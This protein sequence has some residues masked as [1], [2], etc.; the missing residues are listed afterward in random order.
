MTTT[1]VLRLLRS[2]PLFEELSEVA[3]TS[4][5]ALCRE[6]RVAAD[7]QV[8]REGDPADSFFVVADGRVALF[9]DVP[10][11]PQVLRMRAEAGDF[12]GEM[13]LFDDAPRSATAR[14]VEASTLLRIGKSE[15]LRFLVANPTLAFRLRMEMARRHGENA[16]AALDLGRR[17]EIRIRV[18]RPVW[19][20][21]EDGRR[22]DARLE[23]LSVGGICVSGPIDWP[24]HQPVRFGLGPPGQ[25]PLLEVTGRVAW[26]EA[27]SL[28]ITF[29]VD[30]ADHDR[31]IQAALREL[32]S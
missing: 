22:L 31:A 1:D 30:S 6:E 18:D 8:F 4:L 19:L 28:G 21:L 23:N 10:G 9:R 2:V 14:A 15:L 16:A 5:A 26:R 7:A 3:L 20:T 29:R 24:T 13:G 25:P 17:S 27:R 32:L 11:R 12:F